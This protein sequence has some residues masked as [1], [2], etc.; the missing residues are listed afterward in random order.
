[1]S[2][3]TRD[4]VQVDFE[5]GDQLSILEVNVELPA[6]AAAQPAGVA[7]PL[8][9]AAAAVGHPAHVLAQG[10]RAR[11]GAAH[12]RPR[13]G[14]DQ[15]PCHPVRREGDVV[16]SAQRELQQFFPPTA[17]SSTTRR[18]SGADSVA[19]CR[20]AL[21]APASAPATWRP[22]A[23]PTS[24]RPRCCGS[25]RAAGRSTTPSSGR[26]GAP[27]HCADELVADGLEPLVAATTGLVIDPYFSATKL[28]WLL[29][30]VPGARA[31]RRARRA[32][33][34]HGRRFLLWRLTGGARARHRRHQ[35]LAHHAVRHP[36]PGLGRG[37]A[38]LLPRPARGPARGARLAPATSAAT[39]QSCG[40]PLPITGMAGDQ[41]A[42]ALRPGLLRARHGEEHLRHGLLRAAQH[43]RRRRCARATA[44]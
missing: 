8:L 43:R 28:A 41:Q 44:C 7:E 32:R 12:P 39:E 34:R 4:K 31:A 3:S 33:L 1:M 15:H 24:A 2:R 26:T 23:S 18:R 29:D 36:T 22:S 16:A 19:V 37:A 35:R 25:G 13:P 40:A 27:R 6:R 20:E 14:H 17:G 42:A 30:H 9:V 11:H 38:A 10:R 21:A 5:R